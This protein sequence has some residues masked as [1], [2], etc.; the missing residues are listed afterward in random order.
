MPNQA[1]T[2]PQESGNRRE[3][4]GASGATILGG[5]LLSQLGSARQVHAAGAAKVIRI[6]LIGCG[7][8]GTGAVAQALRTQGMVQDN[9]VK[10]VAMGDAFSDRL[11]GSLQS[12]LKENSI[13]AQIDVPAE[14]RF[15]GFDA[16]QKVLASDVDLV[17]LTTPPGFRPIH[18]KA[19]VNAGK[20]IF[21]EKPVAVDAPG[22]REVL[23]ANAEAKN[24][25]LAVGVGLQRHHQ[26]IYLDTIKQLH[27]GVIGDIL[28]LRVYWNSAGVWVNPKTKDQTEMEYQMRNWYYFNWLSGDHIVEQHIH[29][30]DVGNWVKNGYPVAAQGMG[31]RQVRVGEEYGEIYDHHAVEF[32]YGDGSRM[33]S[34]CRHMPQCWDSVSEH[35]IGTKG[36]ADIS[37]GKIQVNGSEPWRYRG[38]SPDP[39]QIEHN[40]L[41]T[42]IRNGNPL[43]EGDNGAYSTMTAILGRMATYTGRLITWEEALN[44]DLNLSPK[45]Y[46]WKAAPPQPVVAIPGFTKSV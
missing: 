31:G 21:M 23:A 4:I 25:G 30:M 33:F 18:F 36:T 29:N 22:V 44:S 5:S 28:A 26:S 8:R 6:G 17:I 9:P 24:K 37:S 16:Y 7:G 46:D 39:Y 3:F 34:Y 32:E 10:L 13:K 20:H 41:F 43:N 2:R 14:R 15:V 27:D 42:S 19:A 11:E 1:K 40:D 35:A 12:I 38:E 45:S